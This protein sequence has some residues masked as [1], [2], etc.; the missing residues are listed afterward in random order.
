MRFID[1]FELLNME[2]SLPSLQ[3]RSGLTSWK[4]RFK[5]IKDTFLDRYEGFRFV[6]I[7]KEILKFMKKYQ[8]K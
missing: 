2:T 3:R 6:W 1:T 7:K 4:V 5:Y 8:K